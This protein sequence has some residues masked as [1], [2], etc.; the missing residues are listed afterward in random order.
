M[1]LL[2]C[3]GRDFNDWEAVNAALD[4]LPFTPTI[5]IQGGARGADRL[6]QMWAIRNSLHCAEVPALWEVFG[7]RAGHERNVSMLLLQPQ[8]CVAFPGGSGTADMVALCEAQGI[9]VWSID[10]TYNKR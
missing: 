1:R 6:A 8:Y 4:S 10:I 3:G 9:P 2:V 7:K 5:V